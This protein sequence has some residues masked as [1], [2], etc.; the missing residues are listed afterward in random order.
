MEI[1]NVAGFE[2]SYFN[3]DFLFLK[4]PS[5]TATSRT[6]SP[7]RMEPTSF[8]SVVNSADGKSTPR[9]MGKGHN[10]FQQGVLKQDSAVSEADAKIHISLEAL[11]Q[12][13]SVVDS[14]CGPCVQ[15]EPSIGSHGH[16]DSCRPACKYVRRKGGCRDGA[17][18]P[19]CH[20]CEW[21][22]ASRMKEQSAETTL[23]SVSKRMPPPGM[24]MLSVANGSPSVGS[25]GHP[26]SCKAPCKY[27]FKTSGCK[28]GG[29]CTRCH[30]CRWSRKQ[31]RK[32]VE[33][34]AQVPNS[35]PVPGSQFTS[36]PCP[37][38]F[39]MYVGN[40]PMYVSVADVGVEHGVQ[41][42]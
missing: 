30:I 22:R 20:F 12:S 24:C 8:E 17:N 9:F 4:E 37:P 6:C 34:I 3:R 29:A 7:I 14:L 25:V 28:D 21:R 38:G 15:L 19:N 1:N 33:D 42:F 13:E 16:P 5:S 11:V 10:L 18:C 35:I 2:A 23:I 32:K 27:F 36:Y 26:H 31:E 40:A 41:S 39:D